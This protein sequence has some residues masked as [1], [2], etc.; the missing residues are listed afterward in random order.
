MFSGEDGAEFTRLEE[1]D[2]AYRDPEKGTLLL[3]EAMD[4]MPF[5]RLEDINFDGYSDLMLV[6]THGFQNI[7]Y[8]CLLYDPEQQKFQLNRDCSGKLIGSL[9]Y[10]DLE[11]KQIICLY[12]TSAQ[13][14]PVTV[15]RWQKEGLQLDM[16]QEHKDIL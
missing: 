11:A 12:H 16:D 2:L 10:F 9:I 6:R 1:Q 14:I 15:Y 8:T 7:A 5:L 4:W 3:P 13:V